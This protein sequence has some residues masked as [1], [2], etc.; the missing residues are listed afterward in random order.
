MDWAVPQYTNGEIH[1]AGEILAERVVGD[2]IWAEDVMGN[3][4]AIHT[5]PMNTFKTTLRRRVGKIDNQA[6]FAQ[7]LKRAPSIIFKLR[8][9]SGMQLQRMQDIGGLRVVLADVAKVRAVEKLYKNPE[10]FTHELIN[11]KDYIEDPKDSGYRGVHLVFRYKNPDLDT[12]DGLSLE[13]QIRTKLQHVWATSVETVGT[14]L[15]HSLKSS[16]GPDEWLDY[17][18]MVGSAFA[19]LEK[20]KVVP[21]H[22]QMSHDRLFK[23]VVEDS[24]VH[25]VR[26]KLA[27]FSIA[28][29]SIVEE[30]KAGSYHLVILDMEKKSVSV[31]NYGR[32]KL[33]LAARE[34]S[35]FERR[36]AAGEAIQVVLVSAGSVVALRKAYPNYFLDTRE[37]IKQ[38]D[39]I[40]K[41]A[42]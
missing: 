18:S 42:V 19:I 40:E 6:L 11:S 28:S 23:K 31:R 5:Y 30:K 7:R 21:K 36:A 27:A 34:Y 16:E 9:F 14:F 2:V 35:S 4:R 24:K 39:R 32:S 1:K 15:E 10:G 38:L 17:F 13:L 33:D 29:D 37:F 22:A 26:E 20:C 41:L 25:N 3:F 12:Y 8:R